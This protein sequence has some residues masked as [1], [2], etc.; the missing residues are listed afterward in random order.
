MDQHVEAVME[1][2]RL[3]VK[4]I[5]FM[6][7]LGLVSNFVSRVPQEGIIAYVITG[8]VL[9]LAITFLTFS[10]KVPLFIPYMVTVCY[11]ILTFVIGMTSPKLSNYLLVFIS[12][13][14]VALYHQFRVIALS[15]VIGL[16]LTN[17][18]FFTLRDSMFVGLDE[19]V[20]FSLNLYV[21]LLTVILMAQAKIGEQM[22]AKVE[23]DH[24]L[25]VEEK[26]R[27]E[28]LL[29]RVAETSHVIETFSEKV[30]SEM[31]KTKDVSQ[32]LVG[33]FNEVSQGV[34]QQSGSITEMKETMLKQDQAVSQMAEVSESTKKLAKQGKEKS[35]ESYTNMLGW[36]KEVTELQATV[37]ETL[38]TI[39]G[40]SKKSQQITSI[41]ETVNQI[42][43]QTNLLALNAA[44]EAARAG[45]QGKG[46]SVVAEEVRKLAQDSQAATQQVNAILGDIQKMTGAISE[47]MMNSKTVTDKGVERATGMLE[48]LTIS[49][50]MM[51]SIASDCEL[52]D[53]RLSLLSKSQMS[54]TEEIVSVQSVTQQS[55]AMV[56]EVF[57][58]VEQQN[59][60]IQNVTKQLEELNQLN[61]RLVA[62]LSQ[63]EN[64]SPDEK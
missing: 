24:A 1:R 28:Q 46:F 33:A 17:Y 13:A 48:S 26:K 51:S 12:L 14:I 15:G 31:E 10:G 56:E 21:L 37:D 44:I 6:F 58:S 38:T 23:A 29:D 20:L 57:A 16:L 63:T 60:A 59:Q 4:L 53:D 19:Q 55:Q 22:R 8:V 61:G 18:F 35:E 42:A 39:L 36:S 45:E 54:L 11:G 49:E 27:T 41:V 5:W 25:V 9:G 34:E 43:E 40:L 64:I 47:K 3:L 7:A 50:Q 52:L 30:L 2:N 62:S 32:E